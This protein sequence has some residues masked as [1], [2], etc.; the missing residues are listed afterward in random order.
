M[1]IW[2]CEGSIIRETVSIKLQINCMINVDQ[3]IQ[4]ILVE[5]HI[6]YHAIP[7]TNQNDAH[8]T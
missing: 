5:I 1:Y 4:I 3:F 8:V 7:T 6:K 2:K